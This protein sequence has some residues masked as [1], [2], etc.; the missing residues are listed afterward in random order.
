LKSGATAVSM[1]S[2]QISEKKFIKNINVP[3]AAIF[4]KGVGEDDLIA[5]DPVVAIV[6]DFK[7]VAVA[8][9]EFP[10][11]PLSIEIDDVFS[12][13]LP[14]FIGVLDFVSEVNVE[15][16]VVIERIGDAEIVLMSDEV[17]INLMPSLFGLE[18][19]RP[20]V[21]DLFIEIG[22]LPELKFSS[23]AESR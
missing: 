15:I 8:D 10:E 19:E 2:L 11:F 12:F 21:C 1:I 20:F 16:P 14:P 5:V 7:S 9:L 13:S 3:V 23:E 4:V 17:A 22:D 6:V 18:N